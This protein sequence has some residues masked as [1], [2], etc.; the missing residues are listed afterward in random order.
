ME[1]AFSLVLKSTGLD[2]TKSLA[3]THC[4]KVIL[5][6]EWDHC[7]FK[8]RDSIGWFLLLLT[9]ELYPFNSELYFWVAVIRFYVNL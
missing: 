7:K 6:S 1:K 4:N 8:M 2:D 3:R 9:T 5:L